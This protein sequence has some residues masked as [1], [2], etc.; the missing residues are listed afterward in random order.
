MDRSSRSTMANSSRNRRKRNRE[1]LPTADEVPDQYI[2]KLKEY[3][4]DFFS[5]YDL[6]QVLGAGAFGT[7]HLCT[8]KAT[9]LK[10][11]CKIIEKRKLV[12]QEDMDDLRN[13]VRIMKHL[14]LH[15]NIVQF[16][17]A[18]EDDQ[19]VYLVMELCQ[20]GELFDKIMDRGFYTEPDAAVTIKAVI[21]ATKV[22]H[23][24]GVMHR[25][26]KP[27]NL[28]YTSKEKTARL[29]AIDFGLSTFFYPGQRFHE[30][31]G[32]YWYMAPEVVFGSYGQEA[33]IWSAGIILYILLCGKPPFS[34][35]TDFEAEEAITSGVFDYQNGRWSKISED[36]KDLVKGMLNRDIRKRLTVKQVLGH[37]LF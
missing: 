10:Y 19:R 11:A 21:Q 16:Q 27:E 3:E 12:S 25:D 31:V 32:S 1:G 24:N 30:Q 36:A 14:P 35:E 26:L 28:L 6:G 34:Y 5:S 29:K 33:D 17:G 7:T 22:C 2:K 20:G 9:G 18:Y 37:V 4:R 13:E 8:A 23:E 15:E